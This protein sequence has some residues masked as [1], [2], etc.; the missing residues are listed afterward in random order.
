[1]SGQAK[2]DYGRFLSI[3]VQQFTNTLFIPSKAAM[4]MNLPV[5]HCQAVTAIGKVDSHNTF[6][7][8]EG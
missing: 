5:G 4:S 7:K 3:A 1:M 2:A 6:I 8:D